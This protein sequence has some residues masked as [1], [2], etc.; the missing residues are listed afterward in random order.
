[1]GR[2]SSEEAG[3]LRGSRYR[4][5]KE[6]GLLIG[7]VYSLTSDVEVV[8]LDLDTYKFAAHVGASRAGGSATHRGTENGSG[9]FG[10]SG[11]TPLNKFKE[12]SSSGGGNKSQFFWACTCLTGLLDI[13]IPH[14]GSVRS[15]STLSIHDSIS[16]ESPR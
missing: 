3:L 11:Y 16:D 7:P 13:P 12:I 6:V 9:A 10:K 5:H 15:A 8:L 14:G 4:R 1:M 2:P